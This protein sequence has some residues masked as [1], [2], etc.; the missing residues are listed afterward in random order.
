MHE[1]IPALGWLV[2]IE[3]PVEDTFA[4]LRAATVRSLVVLA[5]GLLLAMLASVALA[6]RMVA[7]S[8]GCRK[9]RR[10]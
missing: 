4:E 10:A 3:R 2:F 7:R 5:L 9:A 6:R 1:A 8:A